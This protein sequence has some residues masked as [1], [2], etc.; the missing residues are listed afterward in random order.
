M[1][2]KKKNKKTIMSFA[3]VLCLIPEVYGRLQK[4]TGNGQESGC[5]SFYRKIYGYFLQRR[6]VN[7][8]LASD[9][10]WPFFVTFFYRVT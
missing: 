6:D 4:L 10:W 3:T 9:Q 7:S 8:I 5:Q 2:K 1:T